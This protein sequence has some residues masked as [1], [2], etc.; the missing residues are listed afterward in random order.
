MSSSTVADAL[1]DL[2]QR[3]QRYWPETDA[4]AIAA[5]AEQR[6]EAACQT[7]EL[8]DP[9]PL[10]GGVVGLTCAAGDRVV[11]V[12]PRGHPE[13]AEMRGEAEALARWKG[14]GASVELLEQRDDG[15]TLLMP[16]VEPGT[17]LDAVVTDYDEQL[18][19]VGGLV[20]QLHAIDPHI[21]HA[22][23]HGGNVLLDGE[24]WVAV[25]PKGITGDRH[26]DVWLLVCPQA[27]TP[28][29]KDEL[30]RRVAIYSQAAGLD[31][32]RAAAS[33]RAI[34][35]REAELCA[36]SAFEGWPARLRRLAE[37][38]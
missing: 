34:A 17:T 36:D 4:S 9:L 21:A 37:L 24:H 6:L 14:S 22:D 11:K 3:W 31:P 16:R 29:D 18:R 23:L 5:D 27:P 30:Q 2:Q 28:T 35:Q 8:T 10:Y 19:I 7:W 32:N 20:K 12:L 25:D 1:R 33:A 26:V 15:M 38:L 13:G